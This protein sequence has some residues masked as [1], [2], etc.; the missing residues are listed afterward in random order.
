MSFEDYIPDVV[1]HLRERDESIGGD[2]PYK[3][4][5]R[6]SS[7]L[8]GGKKVIIF[9]L[10]GAFTPTCT[11]EQLPGFEALYDEF[12]AEGIDEIWCC[13]VND[14]FVMNAWAKHLGIEK[15][16]MLPDGTGQFTEKLGYLVDKS[17]LGFGK[18]SWRYATLVEDLK[19]VRWFEE[20]GFA[21]LCPADPYVESVP[22]TILQKLRS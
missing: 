11:N 19:Q 21:D 10:P 16:R 8:F 13:S 20:D 12:Q 22:E 14:A 7:E 3:W 6:M 9:G 17:N 5:R 2:N 15:V 4:V 18:R 1:F